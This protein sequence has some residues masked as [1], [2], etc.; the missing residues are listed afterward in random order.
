MTMCGSEEY[1]VCYILLS[2]YCL[3][4]IYINTIEHI[5][6]KVC[7]SW[8][9]RQNSF[10]REQQ[11]SNYCDYSINHGLCIPVQTVTIYYDIKTIINPI[12][13]KTTGIGN[14]DFQYCSVCHKKLIIKNINKQILLW[15]YLFSKQVRELP[16]KKSLKTAWI[17][18]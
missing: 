13:K 12:S 7:K 17:S 3:K 10:L 14:N 15:N 1:I 6:L 16:L 5:N 9:K 8:R 11:S 2:V 4:D 18:D